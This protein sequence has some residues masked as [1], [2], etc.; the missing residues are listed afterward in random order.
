MKQTLKY[1]LQYVIENL[2]MA[3]T[4][5]SIIIAL[6]GGVIALSLG[7][8]QS[9]NLIIKY[10][11]YAVLFFAGLSIIISFFALHARRVDVKFKAKKYADK[12]LLYFQN[13][14]IMTSEELIKNIIKY[15]NYPPN[16]KIDN[17]E[18]D[19]A[20][21]IIANSKIVKRKFQLFNDSAF[22]CVLS[23]ISC[24]FAFI[25]NGAV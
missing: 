11:N 7:F 16:Y 3:E 23:I 15:Y 25:F 18:I 9:T 5:H 10:T 17:L 19:I 4:K 13:L 8:V 2:K 20:S 21:T 24:L 1:I 14:A 22:F 12:N 6:N